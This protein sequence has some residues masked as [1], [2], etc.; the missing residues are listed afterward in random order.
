MEYVCK[1]L[2]LQGYSKGILSACRKMNLSCNLVIGFRLD[3]IS[4]QDRDRNENLYLNKEFK[5]S[6][7]K[8]L[9]MCFFHSSDLNLTAAQSLGAAISVIV[10]T[11][12]PA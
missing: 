8:D 2:L 10:P 4:V 11:G 1:V 3:T 6:F 12:D 7:L 5:S 9:K